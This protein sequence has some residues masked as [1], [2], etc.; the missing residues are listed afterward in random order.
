MQLRR[1]ANL[2]R[3]K[4]FDEYAE[5]LQNIAYLEELLANPR[6]VL[7][8]VKEE[9]AELKSRYGDPRRTEI[10]EQ[11]MTEFRAEDLIPH[12]DM[13]ITL[14]ERG[15]IKRVPSKLYTLQHRGGKGIMAQPTRE[16]DTVRLLTVTDTH[17]SLLFFTNRGK[18][19]QLKCYQIPASS[20]RTAKGIAAINLFPIAEKERVTDIVPVLDFTPDTYLLM[21]TRR[22]EMKKTA[23]V[24]F[25]AV[26]SNGLIAMDV[27]EK[28][29]LI[30]ARIAKD[31][32]D[33]I[34]V[35]QKGLSIRFNVAT[36]R[37]SSRTSGGVRGIRLLPDDT[38]VSMD[39][40]KED[41]FLLVVTSGGFGKLTQLN[42]YPRQNRGG[43]GKRAKAFHVTA[44][45]GD[46]SAAKVVS[47][48]DQVM[49]ISAEG[50]VT[51]TPVKEKDPKQGIPT[52]RRGTKRKV[53]LMR[54]D[55]GD[56]V[57]AITCLA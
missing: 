52:Q 10:S 4:I 24:K 41:D 17:T 53:R 16:D 50:V 20:S 27:E 18:V 57:V 29:E 5:V 1:L 33:V 28:D 13:V 32:D 19:F 38:A 11:E 55:E 25:A 26:R 35:T 43:N 46:V 42:Q 47:A 3:Q 23:L 7:L 37:A 44:E 56:K 8:L 48:T 15:F 40:V 9:V 36:L 6:R 21:A 30:A 54:L 49:I 31:E 22:G 39:K 14:S 51:R 34:M 45:T 12:E 2:E